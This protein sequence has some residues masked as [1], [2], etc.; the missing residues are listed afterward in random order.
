[1]AT[2]CQ[3]SRCRLVVSADFDHARSRDANVFASEG[4]A[5]S[6]G[7]LG[8]APPLA[9]VMILGSPSVTATRT[10]TRS[11]VVA[12]AAPVLLPFRGA[13]ATSVVRLRYQLMRV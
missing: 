3:R 6:N 9:M 10:A 8:S 11:A 5:S 4:G 1:M 7:P 13:P 2:R 12:L